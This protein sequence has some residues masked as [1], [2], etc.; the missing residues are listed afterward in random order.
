MH[1]EGVGAELD[2]ER[3]LELLDRACQLGIHEV[4]VPSTDG[5]DL[6][7]IPLPPLPDEQPAFEPSVPV[8]KPE[9]AP[10]PMESALP[11]PEPRRR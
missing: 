7:F 11:V 1:L 9:Q 8:P 6:R 4:C 10:E 2:I 3:G 5:E